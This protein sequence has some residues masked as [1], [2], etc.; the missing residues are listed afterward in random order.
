MPK[1][2]KNKN[3]MD[4]RFEVIRILV[5]KPWKFD[6]KKMGDAILASPGTSGTSSFQRNL[7]SRSQVYTE[8]CNYWLVQTNGHVCAQITKRNFKDQEKLIAKIGSAFS[9]HSHKQN[10]S[11]NIHSDSFWSQYEPIWTNLKSEAF[12]IF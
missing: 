5:G 2:L 9:G 1:N 6:G 12:T 7:E 4:L 8:V 3:P 10:N 11:A